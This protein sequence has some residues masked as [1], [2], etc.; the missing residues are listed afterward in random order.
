MRRIPR[1]LRWLFGILLA[2]LLAVN[3]VGLTVLGWFDQGAATENRPGVRRR[4]QF[5]QFEDPGGRFTISYPAS[6][7]RVPST[8]PQVPLRVR[9]GARSQDS[10]LVRIARLDEPVDPAHPTSAKK[11]VDELVRGSDVRVLL[12][13][14]I[15]LNGTPALYYLYTFGKPGSDRFGIHAHYF[16][17]TSPRTVHVLVLQALPDTE[18]AELAPVFDRIARSYHARG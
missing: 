1:R 14:P 17:F 18:F 2:C 7:Q 10:L 6:W 16:L 8:D 9:A 15:T 4:N 5:T 11:Q 13:R 12:D 3:A